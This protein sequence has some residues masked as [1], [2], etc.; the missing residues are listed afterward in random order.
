MDLSTIDNAVLCEM[1]DREGYAVIRNVLSEDEVNQV[2]ELTDAL[3]R[4]GEFWVSAY[5]V[6]TRLTMNAHQW[7]LA[8]SWGDFPVRS[9]RLNDRFD[10]VELP[11]C[12]LRKWIV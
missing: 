11:V 6:E 7:R 9:A 4:T 8:T 3:S 1:F 2:Q 10:T 12:P 5:D